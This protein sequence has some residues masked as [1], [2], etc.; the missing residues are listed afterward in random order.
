MLFSGREP[1]AAIAHGDVPVEGDADWELLE[2]PGLAASVEAPLE[3]WSVRMTAARHEFALSFEALSPPA[4]RPSTGG[5]EGYEQLCRVRG[6][7]VRDGDAAAVD[8]TGQR[9]HEWGIQDWSRID[10][11]H[12]LSGWLE[13][14]AGF[15]IAAARRAGAAGHDG[16][17]RWGALLAPGEVRQ[18]ADPRL[19]TT[20]DASGHQ[21]RAGLE[22]WLDDDTGYPLRAAGTALCGSTSS[23]GSCGWT[24]RSCTG[25]WTG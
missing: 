24:A 15:A 13:S 1:V 11:V 7:V 21:R 10:G 19:S 12:T 4:G 3:R 6:E 18:I 22:L 17:E 14:G 23:S 9:G 25:R 16:D 5:M 20:Y 2:L 8:G